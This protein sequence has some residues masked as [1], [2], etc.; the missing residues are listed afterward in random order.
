[1]GARTFSTAEV[2]LLAENPNWNSIKKNEMSDN[3]DNPYF[4][5]QKLVCL[6]VGNAKNSI[7]LRIIWFQDFVQQSI[8]L[9][10]PENGNRS[11]LRT[12]VFHS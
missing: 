8:S 11:R 4:S 3:H 1:L 9:P 5:F 2:V 7:F 12:I 6:F 10:S